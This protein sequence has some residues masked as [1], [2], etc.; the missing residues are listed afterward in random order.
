MSSQILREFSSQSFRSIPTLRNVLAN[1]LEKVSSKL[2]KPTASSD[3]FSD[4]LPH[5][6]NQRFRLGMIKNI[7]ISREG[8][9]SR[10]FIE[11]F[12]RF[13]KSYVSFKSERFANNFRMKARVTLHKNFKNQNFESTIVIKNQ[14]QDI[15]S[16]PSK[17]TII[18]YN[19]CRLS[20]N[21][22][23]GD[24]SQTTLYHLLNTY[25]HYFI[26]YKRFMI[27]IRKTGRR[28]SL[29]HSTISDFI[30]L[31]NFPAD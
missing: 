30:I 28:T 3:Q 19:Q 16:P 18:I 11:I 2:A 17:N 10:H 27:F 7:K 22:S 26:N 4:T 13:R 9:S 14:G 24:F 29:N 20:S 1:S 6:R 23:L 15:N 31:I 12:R 21:L 25:R 8:K 5:Y